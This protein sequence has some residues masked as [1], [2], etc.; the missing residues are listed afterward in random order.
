MQPWFYIAD[1]FRDDSIV[2]SKN[3]F[4]VCDNRRLKPVFPCHAVRDEPNKI[5]DG[6]YNRLCD[7]MFSMS[8]YTT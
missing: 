4:T 1:T 8:D 5:W 7:N 6:F 2:G 3:R